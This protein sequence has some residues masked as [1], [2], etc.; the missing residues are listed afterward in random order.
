MTYIMDSKEYIENHL[1]T[2]ELRKSLLDEPRTHRLYSK[3]YKIEKGPKQT[4]IRIK[5]KQ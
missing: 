5:E 1:R 3:V 2:V 4:I